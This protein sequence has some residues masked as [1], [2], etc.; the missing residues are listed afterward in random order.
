MA[1]ER[2]NL[3]AGIFILVS[4]A[5]IVT[6]ILSITGIQRIFLPEQ[7]RTVSFRLSDDLGGL[8]IGDEV[9]IGGFKVGVVKSIDVRDDVKEVAPTA[10]SST[11]PSSSQP[12][13]P[14]QPAPAADKSRLLVT[15]TLPS[16]YELHEDAVVGVQATI[17]GTACLNIS[18]LGTGKV[19]DGQLAL[20][21]QPSALNALLAT[22]GGVAPELKPIVAD[23]RLAVADVRTKTVPALNATL[24]N[25]REK[26]VPELN[27][28]L[29]NYKTAGA[30]L[31]D[32]LGESKTDFKGTVHNLKTATGTINDKLPGVMDS[33]HQL[34]ARLDD[35]VKNTSGTLEDV[36]ASMANFKTVS[37]KA[38]D[39]VGGNKGK[40]DSMIASLKTT[41]DNLKAASAEIR[42]SPWRLLYKP[43]KGEV[44]N[45]NLYDSARQFADGA[46]SLNE[47]ALALRDALANK[48][49]KPEEVKELLK[50]LD[51]SFANFR[52][53]EDKLWTTVKE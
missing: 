38:R 43:G 45:L 52:Q 7:D 25:V 1:K 13:Q 41:G 49:A 15:F 18:D 5:L 36:K 20:V 23:A 17:T 46:G 11:R 8:Q 42:H 50:R 32:M 35:T 24:T 40:L 3:K 39:V 34:I 6:V 16:R 19:A 22:L 9:R 44:A 37:E 27:S 12:V 2:N 53:V 26:T 4:I 30:H 28:A 33:A 29:T 51:A 10:A 21:G 31:D 48:D 14:A 47:A